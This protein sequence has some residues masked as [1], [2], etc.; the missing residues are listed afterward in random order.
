MDTQTPLDLSKY[1]T[2]FVIS[3]IHGKAAA[4]RMAFKRFDRKKM[5]HIL[6][7]GDI[8]IRRSPEAAALMQTRKNHITA[9]RGNGDSSTDQDLSGIPL[10]LIRNI[11]WNNRKIL[12]IHGHTLTFGRLPLL[13]PGSIL[14]TGHTH[15]PALSRDEESGIILLNPGSIASPRGGSKTSYAVITPARIVVESLFSGKT[16]LSLST[17]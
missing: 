5:S 16:L 3:D 6:A 7:A 12:L 4:L 9:V 8:M 13:P 2:L 17:L 1:E 14:I 10:P 11:I 15:Y